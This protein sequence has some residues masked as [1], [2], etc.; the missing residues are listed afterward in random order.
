MAVGT[1][2]STARRFHLIRRM[3]VGEVW[4]QLWGVPDVLIASNS[5]EQGHRL[6]HP[7]AVTPPIS[8]S[9]QQ[10]GAELMSSTDKAK[11]TAQNA[12]GKV[13]ETV[14]KVSD[15]KRLEAEGKSDQAG[16]NLKQAGE[17]AK[18]AFKG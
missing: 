8:M 17:K 5:P 6:T 13:K 11:N 15:N 10:K 12:K 1:P 2:K 7:G 14:G 4:F 18:D 16:A 9:R 3:P